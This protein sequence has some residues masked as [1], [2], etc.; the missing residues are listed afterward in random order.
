MDLSSY[1]KH[2]G[3]YRRRIQVSHALIF[4]DQR[5]RRGVVLVAVCVR[6][7]LRLRQAGKAVRHREGVVHVG[8]VECG[9]MLW[10]EVGNLR[11]LVLYVYA[12]AQVAKLNFNF[13]FLVNLQAWC[14]YIS[15]RIVVVQRIAVH[16]HS[17]ITRRGVLRFLDQHHRCNVT[18]SPDRRFC[19]PSTSGCHPRNHC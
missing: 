17:R 11:C 14:E 13:V 19:M 3:I 8:I 6:Q 16:V 9:F 12:A 2:L 18:R 5:H 4:A 7:I 15:V 10:R 1:L